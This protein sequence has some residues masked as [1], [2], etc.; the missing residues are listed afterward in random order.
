V[1]EAEEEA[2]REA[3]E[4]VQALGG[5]RP[6]LF[7]G[8][9]LAAVAL[10]VG[11]APASATTF[12]VPSFHAACPNNGTNVAQADLEV[13]MQSNAGD[14][15]ADSI[16][17]DAGTRT[18]PAANDS[19]NVSGT[20]PLEIVGAGPGTGAGATRLTSLDTQNI[21]VVDL[22]GARDVTIRDLTI[23]V[24][25]SIAAGGAGAQVSD[26]AVVENVDFESAGVAHGTGI[27][28][29]G[30]GTYDGGK[31]YGA[32]GGSFSFRGVDTNAVAAG[33]LE[34]SR[35]AIS[36]TSTGVAIENATIPVTLRRS[37]I[38]APAQ[39]GVLVGSPSAL[40]AGGAATLENVVITDPGTHGI[41]VNADS[42]PNTTATVRHTTIARV[43][44]PM[45]IG[46][47]GVNVQNTA[48][49]GNASLT[50]TDSIIR[51]FNAVYLR[52]APTNGAIGNANLSLSYSNLT[53][54]GMNLDTGDGATTMGAGNISA[55]PLFVSPTNFHLL[56]GSPSIDTADPAPAMPATEDF[57]GALRPLDGDGNGNARADMGAFEFLPPG[58]PPPP[59]GGGNPGT[60]PGATTATPSPTPAKKC[61]KGRKLKK[62]KCVK[63]KR[64][65]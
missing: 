45:N 29:N 30:G 19:F 28:F 46:A 10:L 55:D 11:A 38:D 52:Q 4:E 2:R 23:V 54:A 42:A 44:G 16:V 51:G 56:S 8:G 31:I 41:S 15:V 62:G 43:S 40:N 65:R 1:Q 50:V 48:G 63:K 59:G 14:A 25:A 61:K 60:T 49:F 7:L 36:N 17:I 53:N 9:S 24:P 20:D 34:L 35:L 39:S 6:R 5:L 22:T 37:R 18:N 47:L 32:G 21:F 57:D 13:A 3:E 12:C 58:A 64:R 33:D 27:L 26:G